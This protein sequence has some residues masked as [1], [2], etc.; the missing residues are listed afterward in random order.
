MTVKQ[1]RMLDLIQVLNQARKVYYEDKTELM[2]NYEYD[3]LEAELEA[4]ERETGTILANSPTQQVGYEVVSKLPKEA[5]AVPALSLDKTKEVDRLVEFLGDREGVLSWKLDGLTVVLTYEDGKLA[6][7]VTRGNGQIGE[8]ITPNAKTFVN[9]PLTIPFKDLLVIRGEALITYEDF[10]RINRELPEGE[11]PY[12]NPRNLCSGSVRQ[13]DSRITAERS[14]RFLAF[15]LV[16]YEEPAF[17]TR[18]A[19]LAALSI[20]GFEVVGHKKVTAETLADAVTEFEQF[21]GK[22][23]F[24]SDGLVLQIDDIAYGKSLGMTSKFPRDT[25]AFKW[26]DETKETTLRTIEWSASRTGLINPVA[27]FDPVE[28]EGTTVSRASV[29]NV[30]IVEALSLSPGDTIEVYKAN[31]IIPQVA[32]N[33]TRLG[34]PAIPDTCP[35]CGA[36]TEVRQQEEA[37]TLWCPNPECGAKSLGAFVH[38]VGRDAMNIDGLSEETLR[39]LMEEHLITDLPSLFHLKDHRAELVTMEGFGEKSAEKLLANIERARKTDLQKLL[40]SLGMDNVG[41]TASKAIC[42]RFGY[43]VGRTINATRTDLLS[44]PD[45]GETIAGSFTRWFSNIH[46]QELFEA[47]LEEVELEPKVCTQPKEQPFV[48]MTF[49]ITGTVNHFKNRA[50]LKA[51]IEELGGKA[52]GSVSAK[53]TYLINN[54][55]A[56]TSGKNKK[57]KEL[58]IPILTEEE[59]LELIG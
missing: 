3:K 52:T 54:D 4:L 15:A 42:N 30:S 9:V 7:A 26:Q 47:L 32:D 45:I 34:T 29:H 21:I 49:V 19:Q 28:L 40:Y 20:L 46:H 56:S 6:K 58:G 2:S 27:V 50:E 10:E 11:E 22:N 8:V 13:L 1:K 36:H 39:K 59:F 43:D 41:R 16:N 57:A 33:L 23:A 48:G 24:P 53:T 5:H 37:K 25:L 12:K 14:V 17:T 38:F 44:I 51:R 31:M 55:S 18:S 35:V